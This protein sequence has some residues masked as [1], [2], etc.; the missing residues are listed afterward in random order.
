MSA[1]DDLLEEYK[2]RGF[3]W[4]SLLPAS[5]STEALARL[6]EWKIR[7]DAAAGDVPSLRALLEK[8]RERWPGEHERIY[9]QLLIGEELPHV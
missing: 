7:C 1:F 5:P 6:E 2:G 4:L 9:Y 3:K 8:L